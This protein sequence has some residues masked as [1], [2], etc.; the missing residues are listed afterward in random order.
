MKNPI[1][2]PIL[3]GALLAT[4]CLTTMGQGIVNNIV[5]TAYTRI[6]LRST[7]AAQA[8]ATLGITNSQSFSGTSGYI[9]KYDGTSITN[10]LMTDNGTLIASSGD[11]YV[12][13]DV[14]AVGTTAQIYLKESDAA[15]D[16]GLWRFSVNTAQAAFMTRD[17]VNTG[18]NDIY[19]AFRTGTSP[20]GLQFIHGGTGNFSFGGAISTSIGTGGINIIGHASGTMPTTFPV[21]RVQY[22]VTDQNGTAGN[23]ALHIFPEAGATNIIGKWV[24]FPGGL[25]IGSTSTADPA[26]KLRVGT[27]VINDGGGLKHAR[28]STGSINATS[29]AVV[30]NSWTTAFADANYTLTASVQDSTAALLSLRM[31]HI[32]A[33]TATGV[34]VRIENSS[35]GALTGTLHLIAIHD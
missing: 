32:E 21:D 17:D 22:G 5:T 26:G 12:T 3:L 29:S 16:S 11:L 27:G 7:T 23:A 14:F 31:V 1:R 8:L 24:Q 10:S 34:A 25:T 13:N 15:A 19:R 28:V 2:R 30:T 33:L 18:G 9:L 20:T 35:V 6:F 4:I